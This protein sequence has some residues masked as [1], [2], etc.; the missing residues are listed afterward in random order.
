MS[1]RWREEEEGGILERQRGMRRGRERE[2]G[3]EIG[4]KRE[5][6][7]D[8]EGRREAERERQRPINI[9]NVIYIAY[10]KVGCN[11]KN[12]IIIIKRMT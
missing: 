3:R 8:R 5:G 6:G 11:Y 10:S 4:R 1:R 7:K 12:L 9:K 2:R